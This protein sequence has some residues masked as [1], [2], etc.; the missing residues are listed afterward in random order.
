MRG[1]VVTH[2][3]GGGGANLWRLMGSTGETSTDGWGGCTRG[4]YGRQA[5]AMRLAMERRGE[6]RRGGRDGSVVEKTRHAER[7]LER[8]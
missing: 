6:A 3:K 5:N 1:G 2:D 4:R 7:T 8:I